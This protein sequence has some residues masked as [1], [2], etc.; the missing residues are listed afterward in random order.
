MP[1]KTIAVVGTGIS[2]LS[3]AWLLSRTHDVTIYE[4]DKRPGGHSNTVMLDAGDRPVPVDTG[5]IVYNEATYP[6]LTALFDHLGVATQPSEMS[7]AV[8]LADR[9]LEYSGSNL[10]SLFA[11]WSNVLRPRFWSMLADLRRFYRDAPRD[12]A[13]LQESASLGDYLKAGAYGPAFCEDHLLPMAAAI[14]SASPSLMLQ[15]PAASFIRFHDSHGLLKIRN[16][17]Q[18]RTVT[19]GSTVYVQKLMRQMN[20][21]LGHRVTSVRRIEEKVEVQDQHGHSEVFDDVVIATHA[22][23]ALALLGQPTEDEKKLLGEFRYSRSRAV[24]HRDEHLMPRRRR[25]WASWN[26]ISK[27]SEAI[28]HGPTVTYWMNKLQR[29]PIEGNIFLTLNP[30]AEPRHILREENYEHPIFD[31]KAIAAQRKLWSLQGK[32][33]VW[34]CGSYFGAGF[35]EDGLQAGLAV[36]ETLGGVKRPWHVENESGRIQID[37]RFATIMSRA[38]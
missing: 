28:A 7:F 34:F 14:W 20:V 23:Q 4:Q 11:Q 21:N 12:L 33:R 37:H 22:D 16:R 30:T 9:D 29:L 32:D 2:G 5:F 3:A 13:L 31:F 38:A 6:N 15:Y 24:L 1:K 25:V 17:P 18:W 36:A 19:G 10:N 27:N 35:H 8:S 26:Y